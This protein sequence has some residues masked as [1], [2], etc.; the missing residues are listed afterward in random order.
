MVTVEG[1]WLWAVAM[2]CD[3]GREGRWLMWC[4]PSVNGLMGLALL[5]GQVV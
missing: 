3:C 1:L 4:S 2:G 5:L